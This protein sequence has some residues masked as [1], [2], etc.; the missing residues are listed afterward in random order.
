MSLKKDRKAH[1]LLDHKLAIHVLKSLEADVMIATIHVARQENSVWKGI[2]GRGRAAEPYN[3]GAN[4]APWRFAIWP[5]MKKKIYGK[6]FTL[7][8]A[9]FYILDI[10]IL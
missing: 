9:S 8:F 4:N 1:P 10:L 5:L 6:D 7:Q 2:E 3:S